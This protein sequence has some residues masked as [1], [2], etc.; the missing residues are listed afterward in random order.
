VHLLVS[1]DAF[2]VPTLVTYWALRR[3][4]REHGQSERSARKVDAVLNAGI[5]ALE[6]AHRGGV[7]VVFGTDLLGGM[8][9]LQNEE[10]RIRAEVQPALDIIQAATITA[11]RLLDEQRRRGE[12]SVGSIADLLVIDRDPLED[13]TVLAEPNKY[14][15]TV[16]QGGRVVVSRPRTPDM[17]PVPGR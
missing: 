11:A 4:G 13:V 2:L 3:E 17:E 5:E 6:R 10:F 14:I 9:R 16:V 8:H 15:H 1:R 12:L 7:N